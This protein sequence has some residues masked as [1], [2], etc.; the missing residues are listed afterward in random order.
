MHSGL[1]VNTRY[2]IS[3]LDVGLPLHS[4]RCFYSLIEVKIKLKK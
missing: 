4:S 2:M 3:S 1:H